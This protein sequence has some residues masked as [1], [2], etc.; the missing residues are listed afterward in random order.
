M[1]DVYKTLRKR[2]VDLAAGTESEERIIE[3]MDKVVQNCYSWPPDL[4][5]RWVG[6]VQCLLIEVEGLTTIEIECDYTR[7]KFSEVYYEKGYNINPDDK[8][9]PKASDEQA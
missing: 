5:G 9:P 3:T 1:I 4:V 6:Y 7:S 8:I 2:Y